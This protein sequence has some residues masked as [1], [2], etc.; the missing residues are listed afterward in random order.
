[1]AEVTQ[2]KLHGTTPDVVA[3][4]FRA[5]RFREQRDGMY[6]AQLQ[7]FLRRTVDELKQAAGISR[8]HSRRSGGLDVFD[9]AREKIVRHLWLREVID[10]CAAAAPTGFGKFNQF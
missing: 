4:N 10:A 6:D 1:M 9:F 8:R 7:S 5:I 3:Y 2:K